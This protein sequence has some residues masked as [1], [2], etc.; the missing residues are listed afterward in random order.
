MEKRNVVFL[1]ELGGR[2]LAACAQAQANQMAA[3]RSLTH[4]NLSCPLGVGGGITRVGEILF[5]GTAN[6][7]DAFVVQYWMNSPTHRVHIMDGGYR[8]AGAAVAVASD[9]SIWIAMQFGA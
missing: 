7:S 6:F 9:G 3:T 1:Q 2:M 8:F 5:S 4:S